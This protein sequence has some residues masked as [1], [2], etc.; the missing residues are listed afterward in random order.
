M[1]PGEADICTGPAHLY[2]RRGI[3]GRP[4]EEPCLH[5]FLAEIL[6]FIQVGFAAQLVDG[7]LGMAF[8]G[9]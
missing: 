8:G 2:G 5:E 6:P 7:A 1:T 3:G 4:P 9:I